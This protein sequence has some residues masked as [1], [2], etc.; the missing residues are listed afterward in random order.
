MTELPFITAK[1]VEFCGS[2]PAKDRTTTGW[3]AG[4]PKDL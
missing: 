1:L 3:P 2:R 4:Y